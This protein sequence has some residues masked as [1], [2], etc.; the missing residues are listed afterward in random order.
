MPNMNTVT[1]NV[2]N[3]ITANAPTTGQQVIDRVNH[4]RHQVKQAIGR[5][6]T[7]GTISG[8]TTTYNDKVFRND[9]QKTE[10]LTIVN[11]INVTRMFSLKQ[12]THVMFEVISGSANVNV[13]VYSDNSGSPSSLLG[14]SG[15]V[16]AT[17]GLVE[18]PVVATGNGVIWVGIQTDSPI[19]IKGLIE[20]GKNTTNAF[21]VTL[22]P[23]GVAIDTT[24]TPFV[25]I[26][27]T[28]SKVPRWYVANWS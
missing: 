11:D 25:G 14:E 4:K 26:S 7:D 8:A 9:A 28:E 24:K 18:V 19:T 6:N 20:A 3:D 15:V 5:K 22:D 27:T 23:F 17:V 12:I 1:T 16:P 10:I 21:G 13:K 2:V